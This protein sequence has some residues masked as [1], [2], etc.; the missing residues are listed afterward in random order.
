MDQETKREIIMENYLHPFNKE[1]PG[2]KNDYKYINT[3]NESCI[4]NLDIYMKIEDNII[5]DIKFD[6]EACAISTSSTSIIIKLFLNKTVDEALSILD[7]YENMINESNYNENI[8]EE[9]NA[10]DEI[11]KQQNRKHCALLSASGMRKLLEDY[12]NND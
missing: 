4:D 2:N 12:K 9:A 5:K 6:G 8:L 11:Y 10:F 3:N 1:I 7:N